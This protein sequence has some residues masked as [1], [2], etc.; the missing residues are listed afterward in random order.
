MGNSFPPMTNT[1]I[2]APL[3]EA[4]RQISN[5]HQRS[6]SIK[7]QISIKSHISNCDLGIYEATAAGLRIAL[8]ITKD[9]Y[10]KD[11]YDVVGRSVCERMDCL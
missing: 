2:M 9:N 10:E 7:Y 8:P 11:Q 4:K 6:N 5:K 1:A 3:A